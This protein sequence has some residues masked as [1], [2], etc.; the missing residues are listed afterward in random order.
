MNPKGQRE[1]KGRSSSRGSSIGKGFYSHALLGKFCMCKVAS[2]PIFNICI[3]YFHAFFKQ[4]NSHFLFHACVL[5][6]AAI[7]LSTLFKDPETKMPHAEV[8]EWAPTHF[9]MAYCLVPRA[10]GGWLSINR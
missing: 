1:A 6:S 3:L 7:K 4:S 10:G 2:D 5:G 9:W 8:D